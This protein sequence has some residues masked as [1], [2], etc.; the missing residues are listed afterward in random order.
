M[1]RKEI[2]DLGCNSFS[3]KG[4]T[5]AEEEECWWPW[6]G[7]SLWIFLHHI[8]KILWKHCKCC[9]NIAKQRGMVGGGLGTVLSTTAPICSTKRPSR[10]IASILHSLLDCNLPQMYAS[11]RNGN[12]PYMIFTCDKYHLRNIHVWMIFLLTFLPLREFNSFSCKHVHQTNLKSK[13][14]NYR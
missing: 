10:K 6:N 8:V 2:L 13:F 7:T 3:P 14:Q 1:Q 5:T 9:K 12:I 4:K 11:E